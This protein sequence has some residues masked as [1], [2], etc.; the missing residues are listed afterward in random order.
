M[1]LDVVIKVAVK[2]RGTVG[3]TV[4]AKHGPINISKLRCRW[5]SRATGYV[6][7]SRAS[8]SKGV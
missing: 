2:S 6:Q 1:A 4:D 5:K 7:V 8:D 3:R